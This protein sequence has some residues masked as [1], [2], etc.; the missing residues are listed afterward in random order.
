MYW[1][2]CGR[3]NNLPPTV[4]LQEVQTSTIIS[5]ICFLLKSST[6]SSLPLASNSSMRR[7]ILQA[8]GW[9]TSQ[10]LRLSL[11]SLGDRRERSATPHSFLILLRVLPIRVLLSSLTRL[12]RYLMLVL[13]LQVKDS[14]N[15]T[16]LLD[17]SVLGWAQPDTL[18]MKY[19]WVVQGKQNTFLIVTFQ[20]L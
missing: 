6:F 16:N 7:P 4:P 19:L 2:A 11:T 8:S 3:E 9:G 14:A 20:D 10:Y 17:S 13:V 18:S 5:S 15:L 12:A 1:L